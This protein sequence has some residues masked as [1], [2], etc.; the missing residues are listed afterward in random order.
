MFVLKVFK[1]TFLPL[2]LVQMVCNLEFQL[3]FDSTGFSNKIKVRH[4]ATVKAYLLTA[5]WRSSFSVSLS[6]NNLLLQMSCTNETSCCRRYLLRRYSVEYRA[7]R[8]T[9]RKTISKEVTYGNYQ[10]GFIERKVRYQRFQFFLLDHIRSYSRAL[11]KYE[12]TSVSVRLQS[13][14]YG[15]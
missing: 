2:C 10:R 6:Y 15:K 13:S 1:F 14:I 11:T 7:K 12:V 5:I 3:N 4:N 9:F 8:I